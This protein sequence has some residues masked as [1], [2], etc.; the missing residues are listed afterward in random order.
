MR[1]RILQ[2]PSVAVIDGI[3]LDGFRPGYQ[4][5]LGSLLAGV[6]LAEGW[7]EP[8]DEPNPA[9]A[10][11]DVLA[12]ETPSNPANLIREFFPPYYDTRPALAADRR[13]RPRYRR[14]ARGAWPGIA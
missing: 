3:R 7:A 11:F 13:R 2:T 1:L 8:V 12:A 14:K 5:E 4:Y 9:L 6:F 10:T